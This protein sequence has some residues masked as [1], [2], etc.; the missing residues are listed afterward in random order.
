MTKVSKSTESEQTTIRNLTEMEV[1][2]IS[3]GFVR[4]VDLRV[5]GLHITSNYDLETGTVATDARI[6]ATGETYTVT[7]TQPH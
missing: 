2:S 7:H 6:V 4:M 1:E 5:A 3:G